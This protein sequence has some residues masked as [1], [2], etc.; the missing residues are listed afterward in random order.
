M[1]DVRAPGLVERFDLRRHWPFLALAVCVVLLIFRSGSG[2]ATAPFPAAVAAPVPVPATIGATTT[3]AA[4]G[5]LDP[6]AGLGAINPTAA[7]LIGTARDSRAKAARDVAEITTR[8]AVTG[9]ALFIGG[10]GV[11]GWELSTVWGPTHPVPLL[12]ACPW[13]GP[14]AAPTV[15]PTPTTPTTKAG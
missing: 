8:Y 11:G 14:K 7:Q 3:T 13:H 1:D 4:V 2:G 6:L 5:G 15:P 9:C 10:D 12:A